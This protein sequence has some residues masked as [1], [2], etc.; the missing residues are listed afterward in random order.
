MNDYRTLAQYYDGL[1]ALSVTINGLIILLKQFCRSG[2]QVTV[3]L[4]L[5][6]VRYSFVFACAK[7]I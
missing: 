4:I 6:A 7:R 1:T 5:P 2:I 3:L